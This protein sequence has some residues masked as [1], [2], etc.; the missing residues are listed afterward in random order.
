[1]RDREFQLVEGV[2]ILGR[3]HDA[4]IRVESGGVSRHHARITVTGDQ[5]LLEDLDSKNGTFLSA[6]RVEAPL[7]LRDGDQ[8]RLGR[9]VL[10]FR[11]SSETRDTETLLSP[12]PHSDEG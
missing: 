6:Q 9:A 1:M 4:A 2:A 11:I 12:P 5:A 10:T 3:A 8:I 7:L